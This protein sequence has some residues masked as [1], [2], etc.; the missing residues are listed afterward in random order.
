[1]VG[2]DSWGGRLKAF[3]R[4]PSVC[5]IINSVDQ[6]NYTFVWEKSGKIQEISQ[7]YDC[8]NHACSNQT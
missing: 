7:T 8:C 5:E 4:T 1:M 2:E 3:N 6:G